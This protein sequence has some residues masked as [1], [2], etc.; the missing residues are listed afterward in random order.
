LS[1]PDVDRA[2][3]AVASVPRD[4]DGP[5]F[6]APWHA[7]AF[8]LAVEMNARGVFAWSEWAARLGDELKHVQDSG[9][10]AYYGAWLSALERL[11]A[12]KGAISEAERQA[13]VAAWDRAARATPH[14]Q[15]IALGA[16]ERGS[17]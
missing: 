6:A 7:Q 10:D 11:A 12:E 1:R 5:V 3:A 17:R 8:A 9:D 14:G 16:E 15:P 2:L 4:R 13:R